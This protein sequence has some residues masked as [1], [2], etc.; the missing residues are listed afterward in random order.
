[1]IKISLS[2]KLTFKLIIFGA[3]HLQNNADNIQA[4]YAFEKWRLYV[5]FTEHK[6]S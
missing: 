2:I 5:S 1:M 6:Q 4:Q 3:T